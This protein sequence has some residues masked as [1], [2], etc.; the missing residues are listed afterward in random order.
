VTV[1]VSGSAGPSAGQV[2]HLEASRQELVARYSLAPRPAASPAAAADGSAPVLQDP[3][4]RPPQ[5]L[6]VPQAVGG[7]VLVVQDPDEGPAF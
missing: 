2:S 6:P 7:P 5:G 1:P 4:E 3:D